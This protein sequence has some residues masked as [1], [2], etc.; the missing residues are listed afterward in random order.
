MYK[1]SLVLL[2]QLR[3]S[4]MCGWHRRVPVFSGDH[5]YHPCCSVPPWSCRIN[6]CLSNLFPLPSHTNSQSQ[7]LRTEL[8]SLTVTQTLLPLFTAVH[9]PTLT[10]VLPGTASSFWHQLCPL[11]LL[12]PGQDHR[13]AP[14]LSFHHP[15]VYLPQMLWPSSAESLCCQL[16][17][18]PGHPLC[19]LA[20]TSTS[21]PL[22][23]HFLSGWEDCAGV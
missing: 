19:R 10:V 23:K 5:G 20:G 14:G 22:Q 4:G 16:H 15:W 9:G 12:H 7:Q 13:S 2:V 11:Y 18:R 21:I 8:P 1:V 17:G 6:C 3:E